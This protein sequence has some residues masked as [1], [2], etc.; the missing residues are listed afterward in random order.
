M[1]KTFLYAILFIAMGCTVN[2]KPIF[3][4]IDDI[5]VATFEADTIKLKANAFFKNENDIGGKITAEN[6]KVFVEN[7]ALANVSSEEFKVPAN[8][9][10]TVPLNVSIPTKM[11][12]GNND[13][14]LGGLLG[15][16]LQN[17]L[18]VQFKGTINYTVLGFSSTYTID[19]TTAIKLK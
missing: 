8:K 12:L 13:D 6:I 2:K 16:V 10:F 18:K 1:K 3:L 15:A 5:K 4:K 9:D 19:K 11:L 14:I 7:K 17:K